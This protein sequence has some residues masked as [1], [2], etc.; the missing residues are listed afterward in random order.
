MQ[1]LIGRMI[2]AD[3]DR[4][5]CGSAG[6]VISHAF[7]QREFGGDAQ[8]IG[9]KISLDGHPVEVVGVAPA[10]FFGLEVGR[11]F[12]VAVPICAEPWI[13]GE[14]SH[15]SKR[16][17]W[18]LA[19]IGRLKPGWTVAKATSQA[20]AMSPAVFENVPPNYRP[21]EA[22]YYTQY[23]LTALPAGSGVSSAREIS[24]TACCC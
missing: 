9:K 11:N 20:N 12:D 1:P 17:H 15:L 3:D 22:K 2:A 16:H 5:G 23:K 10:K 7:W 6:A 21:Q 13:N 24:R 19:V 8:A 4:P 14:D 18:W